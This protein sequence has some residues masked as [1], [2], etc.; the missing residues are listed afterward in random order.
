[1]NSSQY[2]F[3]I[4]TGEIWNP[5]DLF[6]IDMPDHLKEQ[7]R[8]NTVKQTIHF[9]EMQGLKVSYSYSYPSSGPARSSVNCFSKPTQTILQ[10]NLGMPSG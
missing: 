5:V 3:I 4:S 7:H 8:T 6:R 1:M 10:P 2:F 9:L